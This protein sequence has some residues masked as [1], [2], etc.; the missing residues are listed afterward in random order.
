[1]ILRRR[2]R[3]EGLLLQF[4]VRRRIVDWFVD[5]HSCN[6]FTCPFTGG[7]AGGTKY[8]TRR[9]RDDATTGERKKKNKEVK[10]G[11]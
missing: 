1:M 7:S 8:N 2:G 6:R 3:T 4:A 5:L 11:N 9:A 10:G